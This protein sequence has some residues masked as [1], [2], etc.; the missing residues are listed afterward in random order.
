MRC[1]CFDLGADFPWPHAEIEMS[2]N[3]E[4]RIVAEIDS[5]PIDT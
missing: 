4:A 1:Y 5:R 3:T 2:A